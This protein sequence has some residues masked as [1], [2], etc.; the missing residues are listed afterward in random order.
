MESLCR[1]L[2]GLRG[3]AS[4]VVVQI[5]DPCTLEAVRLFAG[6]HGIVSHTQEISGIWWVRLYL[7]PERFGEVPRCAQLERCAHQD[8]RPVSPREEAMHASS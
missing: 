4:R 5:D 3:G 7:L 1:E 8:F 6:Q 2:R